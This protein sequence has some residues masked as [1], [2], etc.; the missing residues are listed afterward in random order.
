MPKNCWKLVAFA[1]LCWC[2]GGKVG[3]ASTSRYMV[4]RVWTADDG[5]PQSSVIAMTQTRDGYLWL[6]TRDGLVRFDGLGRRTSSGAR[7]P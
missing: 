7:V 4:D 2:L 5:L 6:G 1:G 3:A